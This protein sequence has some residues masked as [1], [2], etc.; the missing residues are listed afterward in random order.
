[1]YQ[2]S[3]R[4]WPDEHEEVEVVRVSRDGAPIAS[5]QWSAEGVAHMLLSDYLARHGHSPAATEIG[6]EAL[7][8]PFAAQFLGDLGADLELDDGAIRIW[9]DVMR[10]LAPP[11]SRR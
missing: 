3:L 10:M 9:L 7:A 11:L 4:I 6:A 2:I 1:M 5:P 8:G